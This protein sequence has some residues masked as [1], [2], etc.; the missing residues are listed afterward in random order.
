[1]FGIGALNF[2]IWSNNAVGYCGGFSPQTI[3]AKFGEEN[4][5]DALLHAKFGPNGQRSGYRSPIVLKF[6]HITQYCGGILPR[7]A[8]V[9]NDQGAFGDE[10][11][12]V[13]YAKFG[14]DRPR[15]G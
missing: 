6:G 7:T 10:Q 11:Y 12:V 15:G 2:N 9:S 5:M 13:L 14:A 3:R 4:T 1:M 8:T